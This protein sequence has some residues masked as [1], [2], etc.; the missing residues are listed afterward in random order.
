MSVYDGHPLVSV[1][2]CAYNDAEFVASAVESVL[3]QTYQPIELVAIDN[4]S[5]DGTRAILERYSEDSRV[6]LFLHGRNG[7]VTTR[8]NQAISAATGRFVS[9]LYGDDYYLPQKLEVQVD[10]FASLTPDY[11]VVYAPGYRLNVVTGERWVE[12]RLAVSGSILPQLLTAQRDFI[13]P[14]SPLV[15]YEC[16]Q[17]YPFHEDVFI[18]GET[19]YWRI[20]IGWKF[21]YID[22]PLV[23]MRERPGNRGKAVRQLARITLTLLDRLEREA[24]FEVG[25]SGLVR[26]AR[27]RTLRHLGWWSIRIAADPREARRAFTLAAAIDPRGLLRARSLAGLG[28]SLLPQRV[29]LA[30][31]TV[32]DRVRRRRVF[33][34][35]RDDLL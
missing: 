31:N 18:E 11:G 8:L 5:T 21:D 25:M 13:N 23:V 32:I 7:P 24:G 1:V 9:L 2:L 28:L 3:M 29:L 16:F 27:A 17:R 4:G 14:V 35:Y 12:G 15:R 6:R 22:T 30:A 20:A 34:D 19:I 33:L 10:R 26:H